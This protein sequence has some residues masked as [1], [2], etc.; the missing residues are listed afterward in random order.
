MKASKVGSP[1]AAARR[2][3]SR[4]DIPNL[5]ISAEEKAAMIQRVED[6]K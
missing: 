2:R 4:F 1:D 5:K 6:L 3:Y